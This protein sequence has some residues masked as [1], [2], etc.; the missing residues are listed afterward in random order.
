M[1]KQTAKQK[2]LEALKTKGMKPRELAKETGLSIKTIYATLYALRD[3]HKIAKDDDGV[4]II[5]RPNKLNQERVEEL[6]SKTIKTFKDTIESQR[7]EIDKYHTWCLEW[8]KLIDKSKDKEEQLNAVIERSFAVIHYL[9]QHIEK[10]TIQV[11]NP[12]KE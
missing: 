12:S 7:K 6:T 10:L 8:R 9:E 2:I 11:H 4:Y 5:Q 1:R 3:D